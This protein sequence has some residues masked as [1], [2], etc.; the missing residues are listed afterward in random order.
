M[1]GAV[2]RIETIDREC[3]WLAH[4]GVPSPRRYAPA[5]EVDLA[6]GRVVADRLGIAGGD[7]APARHDDDAIGKGKDYVH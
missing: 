3:Q 7:Q 1:R 6:D 5:P 2:P 4:D